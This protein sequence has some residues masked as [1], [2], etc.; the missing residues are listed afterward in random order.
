MTVIAWDGK[1]LAADRQGTSGNLIR[2]VTK[3]DRMGNN[4]VAFAG[5]LVY[6]HMLMHWMRGG[7]EPA[8][9][10]KQP[11]EENWCALTVVTRVCIL[12]YCGVHIPA[13]FPLGVH[14]ADGV[15]RDFAL[16]AMA[17]GADARR[18][19]EIASELD[20]SCGGGVDAYE[21]L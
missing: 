4:L 5:D 6:G 1:T 13:V 11:G 15:G 9:W 12:H 19:V 18:A 14:F 3:I 21:L 8:D 16:G 2:K 17:A 7:G 20:T 10:P